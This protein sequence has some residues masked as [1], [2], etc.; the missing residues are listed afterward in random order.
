M[1]SR[2]GS[3]RYSAACLRLREKWV[4]AQKRLVPRLRPASLCQVELFSTSRRHS[5]LF[6]NPPPNHFIT[7]IATRVTQRQ[8]LVASARPTRRPNVTTAIFDNSSTSP[9][10]PRYW[11]QQGLDDRSFGAD[12]ACQVGSVVEEK[13]LTGHITRHRQIHR[14]ATASSISSDLNIISFF[15]C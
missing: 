10:Y 8:I 14:T 7:N 1:G 5:L 11:R 9:R 12:G 15:A 2:G 6:Q 13:S 3:F 4:Q